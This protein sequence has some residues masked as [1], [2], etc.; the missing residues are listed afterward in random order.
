MSE[1][2]RLWRIAGALLIGYVVLTFAGAVS[3]PMLGDGRSAVKDQLVDS[4]LD[5]MIAGGVVSFVAMLLFIP[6]SA[7]IGRLVRGSTETGAWLSSC[8][9]GFGVAFA[10]AGL[11]GQVAGA[12]S[13]YDGHHGL[14]LA[15]VGALNDIR[16]V[17]YVLSGGVLAGF[18][19]CLAAAVLVSR[20]LPRWVAALGLTSAAV[21]LIGIPFGP[22]GTVP[23]TLLAFVWVVALGVA[24]IRQGGQV[25]RS[26]EPLLVT[27]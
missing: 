27:A 13:V 1:F 5:R 23:G 16:D 17:A 3:T 21:A 9:A 19:T 11:L 8:V 15:T 22:K 20:A 10:S 26:A 7:L 2:P 4:D 18:S 6:S 12:V 14:D 24:A 25:R